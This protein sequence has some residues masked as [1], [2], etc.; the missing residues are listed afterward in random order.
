MS[1]ISNIYDTA[2]GI[3]WPG[4]IGGLA[5]GL[6]IFNKLGGFDGGII[7]MLGTAVAVLTGAWL[8]NKGTDLIGGLFNK[9]R[10]GG[11][12]P[13]KSTTVSKAIE[14]PTIAPAVAQYKPKDIGELGS[15]IVNGQ[16][17]APPSTAPVQMADG[18]TVKPG[19]TPPKPKDTIA[20]A[21]AQPTRQ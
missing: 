2:K 3:Q 21:S 10:G 5:G 4:V 16:L 17:V 15:L 13:D 8:A 7:G 14:K 18:T 12:S 19:A 9:I 6:F 11:S 20:L 1:L